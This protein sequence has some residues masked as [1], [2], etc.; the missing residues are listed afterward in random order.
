MCEEEDLSKGNKTKHKCITYAAIDIPFRFCGCSNSAGG[1]FVMTRRMIDMFKRETDATQLR[2][3]ASLLR[4]S[5]PMNL[6]KSLHGL[7]SGTP[8][9]W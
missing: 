5:D 9:I 3:R 4:F 8:N 7:P 2:M 6:E 1:G